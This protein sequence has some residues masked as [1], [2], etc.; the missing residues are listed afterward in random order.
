[1]EKAL[2][3]P[4]EGETIRVLAT[5]VVQPGDELTWWIDRETR[6]LVRSKVQTDLDGDA[7]FAET[8][9][10]RLDGGP[11]YPAFTAIKV[12]ARDVQMIVESFDYTRQ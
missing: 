5:S 1:L 6:V 4:D 9:H 12:P 8:T 2:F 11:T 3:S 10:Q 7:V